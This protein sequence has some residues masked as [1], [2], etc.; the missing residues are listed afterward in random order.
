[1]SNYRRLRIAGGCIFFTLVTHERQRWLC[2]PLARTELRAAISHVRQ[3]RPFT[4]DAMVL[5]PDH[6]HCIWTLPKGDSDYGIRWSLIKRYVTKRCRGQ[7]NAA[8]PV[9]ESRW[10]RHEGNLWQRR[11]WE[12]HIR[13]Q[14]DYQSICDYIHINPVKHGL[15]KHPQDWPYSSIH[16]FIQQGI[17][18]QNW[19]NQ[20][21]VRCPN[22]QRTNANPHTHPHKIVNPNQCSR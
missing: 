5:L 10:K 16:R 15:C 12:H 6:I 19:R 13:S 1:M 4:I 17:Y 20:R 14:A 9:S 2:E 18:P 22:G 21:R 8:I 11:F 7:L 3:R